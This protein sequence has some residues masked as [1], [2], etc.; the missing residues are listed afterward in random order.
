MTQ[1][2]I[3]KRGGYEFQ[4]IKTKGNVYLAIGRRGKSEL[5]DVIIAK[6]GGNEVLTYL[7]GEQ[8]REKF[9]KLTQS[10]DTNLHQ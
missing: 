6:E 5:H 10:K 9:A 4:V 3:Y 2:T 8:A 1:P 7:S